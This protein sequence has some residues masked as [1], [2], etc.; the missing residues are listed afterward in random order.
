MK[1]MQPDPFPHAIIDGW[2][3]ADLLALVADEFPHVTDPR[4]RHFSNALEGKYEGRPAMWGTATVDY[5]DQLDARCDELGEL[6]GIADLSMETVGG[7]YHL[8][9]PGGRLEI[10]TDFNQ[11]PNTGLYRRLNV[12]TYLNVGWDDPGGLLILRGTDSD[13]EVVPEFGRTVMFETSD[14]SWHGHPV[15]AQRW[16]KSVAAYFFSPDPPPGYRRTH[17]TVFWE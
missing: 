3:D 15:P 5:F 11:S 1:L 7:G 14:T 6:F 2:F 10:H 16:R 4:W 8:I 9:P 13:I 12:L 17:S